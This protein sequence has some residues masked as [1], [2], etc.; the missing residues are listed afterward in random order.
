[1]R[2]LTYCSF[3]D[4]DRC[5]GILILEGHLSPAAARGRADS[6]GLDP[7]GELVAL[8]V[9]ENDPKLPPDMFET[10][11][12]NVNRLIPVELAIPLF[13]AIKLGDWEKGLN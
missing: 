8:P 13:D 7:G 5:L 2:K 10:M 4:D 6:F 9:F 11:A 3:A 12:S 1:M